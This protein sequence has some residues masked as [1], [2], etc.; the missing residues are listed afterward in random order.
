MYSFLG[1]LEQAMSLQGRYR[2]RGVVLHIVREVLELE[3]AVGLMEQLDR[4]QHLGGNIDRVVRAIGD[5][6]RN[7]LSAES[8]IE[9]FER[10]VPAEGQR[11][12]GCPDDVEEVGPCTHKAGEDPRPYFFVWMTPGI[13]PVANHL[14]LE[15]PAQPE[16]AID[17]DA[18]RTQQHDAV[19]E[20]G[21]GI[22][23]D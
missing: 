18:S 23:H 10:L 12:G 15:T 19:D 5:V 8:G 6:D 9:Q 17:V 1:G 14:T 7:P 4:S 2:E 13:P 3:D 11:L 22:G 16:S 21:E 20:F